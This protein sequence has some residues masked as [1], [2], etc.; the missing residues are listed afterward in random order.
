[1]KQVF[2]IA[3][4]GGDR[5]AMLVLL[6]ILIPLAA[7][8]WYLLYAP[9]NV[10]F[11]VSREGLRIRG[12]LLYSRMIPASELMLDGARPIDLTAEL[13]YKPKWRTNGTGLPNYK[14]GWFRLQNG[15]KALL[16]VGDPR[17]VVLVPVRS[18]YSVM[19][20]VP[21]PTQFLT[22]LRSVGQS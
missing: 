17:Q 3:S 12:D 7:V 21:E 16:F 2:P 11:E 15:Q 22:A 8:S 1:M 5:S 18:G 10:R 14:A 6:V 13:E 20:S 4:A 9:R 19:I